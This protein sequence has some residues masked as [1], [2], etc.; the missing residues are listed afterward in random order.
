MSVPETQTAAAI[1]P[2]S[3]ETGVYVRGRD[4]PGMCRALRVLSLGV[5]VGTPVFCWWSM[6]QLQNTFKTKLVNLGRCCV[7]CG[8]V[9]VS[10]QILSSPL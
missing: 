10:S 5:R 4:A 1:Y 8:S 2:L 7:Q 9:L 6:K 3:H